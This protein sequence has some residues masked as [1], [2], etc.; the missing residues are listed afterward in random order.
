MDIPRDTADSKLITLRNKLFG[1]L[2]PQFRIQWIDPLS[3]NILASFLKHQDSRWAH[4]GMQGNPVP[5]PDTSPRFEVLAYYIKATGDSMPFVGTWE[6]ASK[7]AFRNLKRI[8]GYLPLL[9]FQDGE[10]KAFPVPDGAIIPLT[11]SAM[12]GSLRDS[13]HRNK[14]QP[15][16]AVWY[17]KLVL[18]H[19]EES[20]K[21]IEVAK[22]RRASLDFKWRAD[23]PMATEQFKRWACH[24]ALV[25]RSNGIWLS[26]WSTFSRK[27]N[28]GTLDRLFEALF[29]L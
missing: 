29:L 2:P 20:A 9:K 25:V 5:F 6:A 3:W 8:S 16:Q 11:A 15:A 28:V 17:I 19:P 18:E 14:W 10:S 23:D 21:A 26:P 27:L 24:C 13:K 12:L 4:D 22:K 1:G 7:P